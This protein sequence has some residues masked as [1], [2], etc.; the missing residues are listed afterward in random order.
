E[1][2]ASIENNRFN[3]GKE[4]RHTHIG[5]I[6]NLSLDRIEDK[7]RQVVSLFHFEKASGAIESLLKA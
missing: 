6:G 4:I 3:P 2:G 1:V 5:S 7:M